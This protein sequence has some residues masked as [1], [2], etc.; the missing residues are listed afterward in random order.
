MTKRKVLNTNTDN[1]STK[2]CHSFCTF[3]FLDHDPHIAQPGHR[4][5]ARNK[6]SAT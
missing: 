1:E 6:E 3:C 4:A 5:S 2:T